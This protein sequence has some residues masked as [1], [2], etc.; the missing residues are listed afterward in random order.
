MIITAQAH[1][2]AGLV[3]NPSDGYF[4][5]TISFVI[6]NFN[7]TVRLWGVWTSPRGRIVPSRGPAHSER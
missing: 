7:A 3:G 5:K 2:R 1:A 4:G 6:R